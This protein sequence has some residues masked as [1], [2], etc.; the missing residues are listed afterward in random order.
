MS[1]LKSFIK[2]RLTPQLL[3]LYRLFTPRDR[4]KLLGL[5]GMMLLAA[6]LEVA[7]IGVIPAF[8][9]T[10]ADPEGVKAYPVI[11]DLI[12]YF[13]IG[14]QKELLTY[15]AISMI[16]VFLVKNGYIL[17]FQYYKTRFIYNRMYEFSR[18]MMEAYMQAP[19][20]FHL[21][22]NTS[23]LLRNTTQEVKLMV[24][25]FLMPSMEFA[26][27]AV[28][29]IGILLFLFVVEPL[30][31]LV[32]FVFLGLIAGGFLSMTSKKNKYY[33][34]KAQVH[35]HGA[36]KSVSQGLGGLKDSRVLNRE[37]YFM[38]QFNGEARG[39]VD[40]TQYKAFIGQIPR[41]LIETLAV[42][43]ML[44]IAMIMV[45]QGRTVAGIMPILSLF[46]MAI[47]RLMPAIQQVMKMATTLRFSV[48]SVDPVHDDLQAL[49]KYTKGFDKSRKSSKRLTVQTTIE[50]SNLV[51]H[52][53]NSD[54]QALNGVS[55]TI[56]RGSA[57]AFTGPSGAGK[58]TIADV[59][60]GLLEPQ[61]GKITVDEDSIHQNLSAWQRNIGY[62]PQFIYLADETLRENIAFG[63]PP[64]QIDEAQIQHAV[65]M[66]QLRDLV[67][68]LPEGLDTVIGERGTRLSG[69]QRQRVGIARALYHDP[70]VLVMDEATSALDNITEKQIINAIDRLKGERTVIMIAHRLTTVEECDKI[71]FLKDGQVE[72]VGTYQELMEVNDQFRALANGEV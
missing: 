39:E 17:F 14:T 18:R 59:L 20:T 21:K 3:K 11:G 4:L 36:I 44:L 43:G 45:W 5:L 34:K 23:E 70:Q 58:T 46:G 7:G 30:I 38:N 55:F 56:P 29:V 63:L 40:A 41:P 42:A 26:Q 47:V 19:Y 2:N 65:D 12:S 10:I 60:L 64:E 28:L 35:R 9:A 61:Q 31:T 49:K 27:R 50:A 24:N 48:V 62:I 71:Y 72:S 6:V 25:Q 1:T 68:K 32:V 52:Y 57:V 16:V 66:A 15:G 22:R 53:P 33:G 67:E 51:Y 54:E 69:G 13:G 37:P 8:V